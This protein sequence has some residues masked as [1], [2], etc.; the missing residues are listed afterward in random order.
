MPSSLLNQMPSSILSA[1]VPEEL[2]C[3]K[4]PRVQVLSTLSVQVPCSSAL[5]DQ[6]P[7]CFKFKI[8]SASSTFNYPS[9][10]S[11]PQISKCLSVSSVLRSLVTKKMNEI[12]SCLAWHSLKLI[13]FLFEN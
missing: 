7:K 11:A 13:V 4:C 1:Q 12:F 2:K 8:Q 10:L 9:D 3:L 5:S 6:F